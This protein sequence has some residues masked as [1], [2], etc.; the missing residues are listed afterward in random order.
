M[1]FIKFIFVFTFFLSGVYSQANPQ[2]D[3][4]IVSVDI[5]NPVEDQLYVHTP[6]QIDENYY[7]NFSIA[8]IVP[9]IYIGVTPLNASKS[10]AMLTSITHNNM[11][12][13]NKQS[14]NVFQLSNI[15][16][17]CNTTNHFVFELDDEKS[18]Y[19]TIFGYTVR[20][21]YDSCAFTYELFLFNP[22]CR[23]LEA[24]V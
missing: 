17:T 13:I 14:G 3:C 16:T 22:P 24:L 1:S 6:F 18:V 11:L 7:Y 8:P 19:V 15:L 10:N 21:R 4:N 9:D 2:V 5:F 20:A 23:T 12:K